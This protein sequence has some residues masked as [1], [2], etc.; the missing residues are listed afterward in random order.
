MRS[1]SIRKALSARG[2]CRF[3]W[4]HGSGNLLRDDRHRTTIR[5]EASQVRQDAAVFSNVLESHLV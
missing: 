5:G 1:R 4:E 3:W 2:L